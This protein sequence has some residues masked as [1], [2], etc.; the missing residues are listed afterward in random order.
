ME[1]TQRKRRG[2]SG[3]VGEGD[4]EGGGGSGGVRGG[5]AEE[6]RGG[7]GGVGGGDAEEEGEEEAG[8]LVD[9]R[10]KKRKR[11]SWWW[12]RGVQ[13]MAVEALRWRRCGSRE[14]MVIE[15]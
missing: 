2:G 13:Y 8:E 15:P 10:R 7:S 3:G 9:G 5:D 12:R 1:V 6:E 4:A 11:R 14:E